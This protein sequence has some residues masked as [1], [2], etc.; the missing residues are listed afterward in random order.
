MS[1]ASWTFRPKT[2]KRFVEAVENSGHSVSEIR[3]AKDGTISVATA[4]QPQQEDA[5]PNSFDQVLGR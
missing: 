5:R 3:L 1:A 2:L 4:P